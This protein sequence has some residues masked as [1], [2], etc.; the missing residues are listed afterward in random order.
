MSQVVRAHM[1]L[2]NCTKFSS[3][4]V[5]GWVEL[6]LLLELFR[7]NYLQ[8]HHYS[9]CKVSESD[10]LTQANYLIII[11][12]LCPTQVSNVKNT[13]LPKKLYRSCLAEFQICLLLKR[14]LTTKIAANA[15]SSDICFPLTTK[16][17][18]ICIYVFMYQ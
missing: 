4:T 2:K 7:R 3:W 9:F 15:R 8:A 17:S 5:K 1:G 12:S 6:L 10:T 14:T 13:F 11:K 18:Q 16:P